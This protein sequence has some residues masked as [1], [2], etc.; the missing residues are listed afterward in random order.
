[1]RK[2]RP[3]SASRF[4]PATTRLR[5]RLLGRDR[6]P[7]E[8]GGDGGQVLGGDQRH[9]PRAGGGPG[10]AVAGQ[11]LARRQHGGSTARIGATAG[12][13][14]GRSSPAVPAPSGRPAAGPS[15]SRAC[16]R[17]WVHPRSLAS[18][19]RGQ[20]RLPDAR[21]LLC[22][23]I[24]VLRRAASGD[25]GLAHRPAAR[26]SC[27]HAGF[28]CPRRPAS[29]WLGNR[30]PD[31]RRCG[32]DHHRRHAR[33][34][35]PAR[36]TGWAA[37][38]PRRAQ[39]PLPRLPARHGGRRGTPQPRR[40]GQLLDLAG[41]HVPLRRPRST[42]EDAE[43]VAAQLYVE[44][45]ELGFTGVAEFHYLHHQPDGTPYADIAEMA[46]R[47]LAAARRAGIGI[48]LLP[49]LYRHGGIFGAD[50]V[51]GQRR[52]LNDLHPFCAS[53]EPGA[54]DRAGDPQ[55]AV[56][57]APHSL[58]A[59]TP[60][61]L[62][63]SP[64]CPAPVHIH[65]AEQLKEVAEAGRHRRRAGAM[66]AGQRGRRCPL[67]PDPRH[68]YGRP[69]RRRAWPRPARSPASAPRPRP[70]SA[71]APSRRGPGWTPAGARHRHR[72]PCRHLPRDELRQLETSQRL[73]LH[74]RAVATTEA[75]PHPGR[76]LLDAALAGGAQASGRPLG[77]IAPGLRC[78]L[79]ELDA[80]HPSLLGR[81]GMACWMPGCFSGQANPV[82]TVVVGGR[83][84]V[85][86]GRHVAR[87]DIGEAFARA[88]RRL[89]A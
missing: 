71:T 2:R 44:L 47:H 40:A 6:R 63:A 18:V 79:V 17:S 48:T 24:Y 5:R 10:P 37:R 50:P 62:E 58:R 51:P 80:G 15:A 9:L 87:L 8:I 1:M 75:A 25:H 49:G 39:P 74:E 54:R 46:L 29:R 31:R 55:A 22:P 13:G 65:A 83:R 81:W 3:F 41:H 88:M 20:K 43:A 7:A 68:P 61:M 23:V 53:V 14:A 42:P 4:S 34:S 59:V 86:A 60:A 78:D 27:R 28:P 30:C 16:G 35:R 57:M 19:R 72:Q 73:A 84:V 64:P 70:R 36:R 12:P 77:G 26:A 52:F 76:L 82:R 33:C 85:E 45:L 69:P 56:G 89:L 32:R 38:C 67:V 21:L 66:A 11:A